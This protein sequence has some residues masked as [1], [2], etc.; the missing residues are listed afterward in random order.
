MDELIKTFHVD[1]K[2]LVAQLVNFTI[3]LFVL[4]RFAYKPILKNLNDRTDK[5]EKGIK[6]AEDARIKIE[7]IREKEKEVLAEAKK[8][9]QK[10]ISKAEETAKK[11][12]EEIIVEA[13]RE[14]DEML[15]KTEKKMEEEKNKMF[16]ELKGEIAGLVIVAAEKIISEKL[17]GGK[18]KELIEKSI[19]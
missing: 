19:K 18:D 1:I 8:E 17:D 9:A 4:H 5:I 11:N 7:E 3:V 2:L 12:K 15:K 6:D 16:A 13:K 14:S 10:I